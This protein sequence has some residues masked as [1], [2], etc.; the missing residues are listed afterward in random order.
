MS[1]DFDRRWLFLDLVEKHAVSDGCTEAYEEQQCCCERR[2][3]VDVSF[4]LGGIM[5]PAPTLAE[6]LKHASAP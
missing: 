1:G 6:W 4:D 2:D 5:F 3:P